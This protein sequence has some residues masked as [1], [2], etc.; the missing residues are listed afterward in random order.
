M[1]IIVQTQTQ[2]SEQRR[3]SIKLNVLNKTKGWWSSKNVHGDGASRPRRT[4]TPVDFNER[5]FF[6][7][8]RRGLNKAEVER[9]I[10]APGMISDRQLS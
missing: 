7:A 10:R 4:G 9:E 1:I 5:T 6:V 2:T 8:N 3:R